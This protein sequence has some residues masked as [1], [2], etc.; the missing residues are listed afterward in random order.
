MPE[1]PARTLIGNNLPAPEALRALLTTTNGNPN[2]LRA[3]FI[4][5]EVC[6]E[7]A[8]AE[9]EKQDRWYRKASAAQARMEKVVKRQSAKGVKSK[10]SVRHQGPLRVMNWFRQ[11][12]MPN[13]QR[14]MHARPLKNEYEAL[15]A[16][17]EKAVTLLS[18][19]GQPVS[20]DNQVNTKL[21]E[22]MPI[23][24]GARI[25]QRTTDEGW[26][27]RMALIHEGDNDHLPAMTINTNW[28]TGIT[29]ANKADEFLMPPIRLSVKA[30][31]RTRG[32]ARRHVR[33]NS[34]SY[35]NAGILPLSAVRYGFNNP[36]QIIASCLDEFEPVAPSML[37]DIEVLP[38]EELDDITDKL[39][40]AFKDHL[41]SS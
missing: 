6:L 3:T 37:P 40:Q 32:S 31:F 7:L 8:A 4:R 12:E 35:S 19:N 14:A 11:A 23:L 9:T 10:E 38:T 26:F 34:T 17:A 39:H 22:F 41:A 24:L 36:Q 16:S 15:L 27:G 2:Q 21:M 5:S 20:H 13:W 28:D 25:M 18:P 33:Q 29:L 30:L 1:I